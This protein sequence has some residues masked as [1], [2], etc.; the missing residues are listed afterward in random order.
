MNGYKGGKQTFSN[1]TKT[2]KNC[3]NVCCLSK[4]AAAYIIQL[5][6]NEA[7]DMM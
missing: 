6:T 7:L 2:D 4:T 1:A 3:S 5:L